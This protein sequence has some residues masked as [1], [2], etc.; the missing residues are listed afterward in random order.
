MDPPEEREPFDLDFPVTD[1]EGRA[2]SLN[3]LAGTPVALTFIFTRCPSP[4]MCPLMTVAMAGLEKRVE[5]E[6]L[7]G[8][9]RLVLL[10]YDPVF[11]TPERL[12]RYGKDR[13]L[14]FTSAVMLRPEVESFR[15]LLHEFQVGVTYNPDGSIGHF[16]ELILIDAQGRFVRDYQGDI[17]DNDAVFADLK[18]LVA[19]DR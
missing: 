16:I 14:V 18:R 19:E 6:G 9:V 3:D 8:Q 5:A 11:D 4:K 7:T 12:K 13:G 2:M 10:T 17:W 1:Q 15:E